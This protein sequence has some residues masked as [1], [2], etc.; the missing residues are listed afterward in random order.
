MVGAETG[1]LQ[2][3]GHGLAAADPLQGRA[4]VL[5][6]DLALHSEGD[7]TRAH[8]LADEAL[9]IGLKRPA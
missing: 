5:L 1:R 3:P 7:V 9:A 6:A 8:D 2:V 4:L